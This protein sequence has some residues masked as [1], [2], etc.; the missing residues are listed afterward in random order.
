MAGGG[1]MP[2]VGNAVIDF[3]DFSGVAGKQIRD[4]VINNTQLRGDGRKFK[5]FFADVTS[6]KSDK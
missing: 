3:L 6:G 5:E 1:L 4:D 2:K